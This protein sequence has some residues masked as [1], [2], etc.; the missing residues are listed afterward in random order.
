MLDEL[1]IMPNGKLIFSFT[2]LDGNKLEKIQEDLELRGRFDREKL[3][4]CVN[5]AYKEFQSMV[6]PDDCHG[7]KQLKMFSNIMTT[8]LQKLE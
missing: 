6:L 3:E 5:H 7:Q 4:K 1:W 8:Y 2:D